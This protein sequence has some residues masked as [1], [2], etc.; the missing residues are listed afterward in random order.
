[1]TQSDEIKV[2]QSKNCKT[3]SNKGDL[4]YQIGFNDQSEIFLRITKNSGGGW[5]SAEWVSLDIIMAAIAKAKTPLTSYALQSLFKGKSVNTP[6]FLFA[7]LK[8]E[9]FVIIDPENVRCYKTVPHEA[10]VAKYKSTIVKPS[11]KSKP[12]KPNS[13]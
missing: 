13:P 2:L 10:I 1:M 7:A 12:E 8:Q 6:A 11:S 3:L 5:F 9:G 4:A